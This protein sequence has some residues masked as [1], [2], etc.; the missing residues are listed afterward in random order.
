MAK[1]TV[2]QLPI[3]T[4]GKRMLRFVAPVYENSFWL[5]SYF[6]AL[7]VDFDVLAKYFSELRAQSHIPS[8]TWSIEYLERKYSVEP[9]L[10][11]S[12]E[13]RR[14]RL[15]VKAAVHLPL[16][17]AVLEKVARENYDFDCYLD[18]SHAGFINI[19]ANRVPSVNANGFIPWLVEEKPAHL[20][21]EGRL[22]RT[23]YVGDER[24]AQDFGDIHEVTEAIL[25]IDDADKKH[26]PRLFAGAL[27]VVGG[28]QNISL[29]RPDLNFPQKLHAATAELLYGGKTFSLA[30]PHNQLARFNI[31]QALF[32]TGGIRINTSTKPNLDRDELHYSWATKLFAG[33]GNGVTG[34]KTFL[35]AQP[36]DQEAELF[37]G[38]A[39]IVD[40][41]ITLQPDTRRK[42]L[43]EVK[44]HVAQLLFKSGDIRIGTSTSPNI[45]SDEINYAWKTELTAAN[46][47]LV[48]GKMS[49]DM[50]KP[51][52]QLVKIHAGQALFKSGDIRID[53]S[54][55]PTNDSDEFYYA[56][57]TNLS[58]GVGNFVQGEKSVA[59]DKPRNQLVKL[60][61]A[62]A[63]SVTGK[64][65]FAPDNTPQSHLVTIRVGSLLSISGSI[66]ISAAP[67]KIF[68][69]NRN[70]IHK[71][72]NT[73]E[74][75]FATWL[76]GGE[77]ADSGSTFADDN[78]IRAMLAALFR[79]HDY[80]KVN[81]VFD[82]SEDNF[83]TFG[84][85]G[86]LTDAN[87]TFA[88]DNEIRAMVSAIFSH[89]DWNKLTKVLDAVEGNFAIFG[90]NGE[91]IDAKFTFA[92]EAAVNA[93]LDEIFGG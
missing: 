50:D 4:S 30:T 13:E 20:A 14:A 59:L 3:T 29:E 68:Y 5:K 19:T 77:L 78:E 45:D 84:L 46:A 16:N 11:L 21:L 70:K 91:L 44:L 72:V 26:F 47:Q 35:P 25:P 85:Y 28:E 89:N 51:R 64:I 54:T 65:T 79:R 17:P 27:E 56:W 81:K 80:T 49:L 1:Y 6:D 32:K 12:L 75:N 9:A 31:G 63:N 53:T 90:S 15:K 60:H 52:N 2:D 10:H 22:I 48:A 57:R 61:A 69:Y 41:N 39:Q 8:A 76:E 66:T 34:G 36:R 73:T 18:E 42:F 87:C 67:E 82:A 38:T 40:G 7:G 86:D 88:D 24:Y 55:V 37:A 71:V 33:I 58:V 93:M 92:N 23:Y 43:Q 74:N 62:Q 83:A